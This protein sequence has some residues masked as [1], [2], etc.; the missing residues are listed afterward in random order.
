M[1]ESQKAYNRR[2]KRRHR[3]DRVRGAWFKIRR[4]FMR[5]FVCYY[6]AH[7]IRGHT[8]IIAALSNVPSK[9]CRWCNLLIPK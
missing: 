8:S 3:W 7:S 2:Y 4:P 9:R 6:R 5:V 1:N